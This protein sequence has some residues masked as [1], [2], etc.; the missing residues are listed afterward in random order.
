VKA[1]ATYA[2]GHALHIAPLHVEDLLT[3]LGRSA[4]TAAAR[5][6]RAAQI[7]EQGRATAWP[8]A[9]NDRCWCGS[10]RN[11]SSVAGRWQLPADDAVDEIG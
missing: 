7:L 2:T 10:G 6:E 5:S 9:R 8:P 1:I 4:G 11:T 3:E